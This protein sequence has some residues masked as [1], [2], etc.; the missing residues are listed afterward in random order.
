VVRTDSSPTIAPE[1][2][3]LVVTEHGRGCDV[4]HMA[5][6]HH[7][8]LTARQVMRQVGMIAWRGRQDQPIYLF[9]EKYLHITDFFLDTFGCIAQNEAIVALVSGGFN[10][11][12]DLREIGILDVRDEEANRIGLP[13]AQAAGQHIGLVVKIFDGLL[14]TSRSIRMHMAALIEHM[15]HRRSRNVCFLG[16]VPD[17]SQR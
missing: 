9:T 17:T 12:R 3:L 8:T 14:D 6:D 1:K 5:V 15:R 16:N 2:R 10:C 11:G 13:A 4:W 7:H